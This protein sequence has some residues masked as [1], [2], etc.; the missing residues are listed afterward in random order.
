LAAVQHAAEA[1]VVA[2]AVMEEV[3]AVGEGEVVAEA[4]MK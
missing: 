1:V 2:V 3:V 4:V